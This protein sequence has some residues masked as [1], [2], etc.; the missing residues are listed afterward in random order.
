[1]GRITSP[2]G[3]NTVI[4]E[5]LTSLEI[6]VTLMVPNR[7]TSKVDSLTGYFSPEDLQDLQRVITEALESQV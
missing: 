5:P 7:A 3:G 6:Q 2:H 4:V 1:M